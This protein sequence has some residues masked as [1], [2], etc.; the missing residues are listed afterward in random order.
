MGYCKGHRTLLAFIWLLTTVCP[1]VNFET[2]ILSTLVITLAATVWLLTTVCP[3]VNFEVLR[4]STLVVALVTTKWL[5]TTVCPHVSFEAIRCRTL[6]VTC[7]ATEWFCVV[8]HVHIQLPLGLEGLA[9]FATSI[10][11]LLLFLKTEG[12]NTGLNVALTEKEFM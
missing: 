10:H 1:H 6:V 3:H 12:K 2:A 11:L 4:C 5:L 8:L 9:A 7:V